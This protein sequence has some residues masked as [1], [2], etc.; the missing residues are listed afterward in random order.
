MKRGE[1]YQGVARGPNAGRG[2]L[3]LAFFLMFV[4]AVALVLIAIKLTIGNPIRT[5]TFTLVGGL[6][7]A[8]FLIHAGYQI[9]RQVRRARE[10]DRK[11]SLPGKS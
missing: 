9:R 10:E 7:I 8:A 11:E 2:R 1:L 5:T 3:A 6:I 4:G